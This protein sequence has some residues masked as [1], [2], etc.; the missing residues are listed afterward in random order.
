MQDEFAT[1]TPRDESSLDR[2]CHPGRM[3]GFTCVLGFVNIDS[4]ISVLLYIWSFSGSISCS[5]SWTLAVVSRE[6]DRRGH[7]GRL[8]GD[9][10]KD[11]VFIFMWWGV[12]GRVSVQECDVLRK[13][14]HWQ[15]VFLSFQGW[16]GWKTNR[17]PAQTTEP[18]LFFFPSRA[19]TVPSP[20]PCRGRHIPA[21]RRLS[22]YRRL[23]CVRCVSWA[24]GLRRTTV[25]DFA[26]SQTWSPSLSWHPFSQI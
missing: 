10:L 20:Q 16:N 15:V 19:P 22:C 9:G 17:A 26:T 2:W 1:S 8:K 23:L 18:S 4:Q 24:L 5:T 3:S 12:G 14:K 11:T 25:G 21:R 6:M 7:F 13:R